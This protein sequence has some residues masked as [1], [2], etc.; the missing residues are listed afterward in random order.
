LVSSD[1]EKILRHAESIGGVTTSIRPLE[2]SD[3]HSPIYSTLKYEVEQKERLGQ[4]F[5]EVWLISATA[6]MISSIDL[7]KLALEF[8]NKSGSNSMLAVTEYEV[9]IQWAMTINEVG[10]LNSLDFASF[11]VRSQDLEKYYHDAGCLAVFLPS[12]F[13]NYPEGIPEGN[14]DPFVLDRGKAIDID[15]PVDLEFA[16]ALLLIRKKLL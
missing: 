3:D 14:F 5:D 8:E 11:R 1:D 9:P 16:E 10:R 6:C 13:Q 7:I 15:Y 4:F 12:V 2:L